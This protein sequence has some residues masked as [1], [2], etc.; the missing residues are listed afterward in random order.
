MAVLCPAAGLS[1]VAARG[2]HSPAGAHGHLT[3][4]ASSVAEHRL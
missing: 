3:V 1:L 2:G 4:G